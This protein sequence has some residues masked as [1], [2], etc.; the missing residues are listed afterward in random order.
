M[1]AFETNDGAR[2]RAIFGPDAEKEMSSGDPV[3]DR[4]DREVMA[5]AM[6]Q[7]L[8]W[9]PLDGGQSQLVIG[10]E[11]WPFPVPLA[12]V[13]NE[14][15]FD[16][17]AGTE[18]LLSRRVGRNELKAIEVCRAYVRFQQEYASP[19]ARLIPAHPPAAG[20]RAKNT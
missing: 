18:E 15:E 10:D 9:N 13:G 16:S 8:K 17:E 2:M 6:R 7:S 11:E 3:S 12:K 1:W 4:R 5:V 20:I 14:W 19:P